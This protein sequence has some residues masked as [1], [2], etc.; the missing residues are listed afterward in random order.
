MKKA[1][2][3]AEKYTYYNSDG[4]EINVSIPKKYQKLV[5]S[6]AYRIEDMDTSTDEGKSFGRSYLGISELV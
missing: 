2:S 3:V 6:G 4:G 1:N 5:Q